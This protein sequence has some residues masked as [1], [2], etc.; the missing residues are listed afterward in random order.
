MDIH[1]SEINIINNDN[2][3]DEYILFQNNFLKDDLKKCLTT[4]RKKATTL[5]RPKPLLNR[6]PS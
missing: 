3:G 1:D 6:F 4:V 5:A 2:I